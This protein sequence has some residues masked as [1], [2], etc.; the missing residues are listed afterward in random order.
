M[1]YSIILLLLIAMETKAQSPH[2]SQ[3]YASPLLMNP[4]LTGYT[5]GGYRVAANYRSQ[6]GNGSSPF[7]TY[8]AS[9]ELSPLRQKIKSGDRLGFG[10]SILNDKTLEGAVQFS[11]VSFSSAYNIS[12]DPDN[13]HTIGLGFQG[14]YNERLINFSKLNFETQFTSGGFDPS[15]PVGES[16]PQGKKRYFDMSA[17]TIYHAKMEDKTLYAGLSV[18]N[19]LKKKDVFL[20]PAFHLPKRFS[21]MAGGDI[22]VGE[23]GIVSFSANHQRQGSASET[24][25]GSSYGYQVGDQ[26]KNVISIGAW[27]RFRDA[28]IPYVGYHYSGVQV[29][30]SFDYTTSALKTSG[31]ARNGFELSMVYTAPDRSEMRRLVP[32]Y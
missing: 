32:W 13:I 17:G 26:E 9:A 28:I 21:I 23:S 12:L 29:G 3:F 4:A 20:D 15:L 14:V 31:Q 18:Y 30:F 24:T 7:Q 25:I 10:I 1:K 16:L 19:L 6:W 2:F 22:D 27:Y 11:S 5:E 8:S